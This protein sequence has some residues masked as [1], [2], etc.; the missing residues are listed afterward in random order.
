MIQMRVV[1]TAAEVNRFAES[2]HV[3]PEPGLCLYL[4][5]N[6]GETVGVCFYRFTDFG[7]RI[8]AVDTGDDL[9]LFDGIIRTT[10][11][12]LFDREDD[13]VE[14]AEQVNREALVACRFVGEGEMAIPSA[15]HFFET[16]K[17]CKN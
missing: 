12:A 9:P 11:A 17:N 8:L 14:F 6:R 5:E 10:M 2:C 3:T 7:M 15:N 13:R 4:A 16:C 1:Q